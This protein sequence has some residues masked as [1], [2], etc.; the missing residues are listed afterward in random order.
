ML[1]VGAGLGS[2][3]RGERTVQSAILKTELPNLDLLL[4]LQ[5]GEDPHLLLRTQ[6]VHAMIDDLRMGYDLIL[7]DVPALIP[8]ADAAILLPLAD[9]VVLLAMA[10]KTRKPQLRRAREICLGM[11]AKILGL[12]VGNLQEAIP[13]YGGDSYYYG[14]KRKE[15]AASGTSGSEQP[16]RP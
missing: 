7:I 4:P 13:G 3:I 12:V 8:V 9:G 6:Q 11:G 15:A 2:V 5:D 1:E 14:H 10:G 16:A